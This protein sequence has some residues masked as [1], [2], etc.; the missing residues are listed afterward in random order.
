MQGGQEVCEPEVTAEGI[1]GG[2]GRWGAVRAGYK[3]GREG[4]N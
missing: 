1:Q 3:P 4:Y 2:Q